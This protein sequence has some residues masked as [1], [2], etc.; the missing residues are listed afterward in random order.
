MNAFAINVFQNIYNGE[1]KCS[2]FK[3]RVNMESSCYVA[4]C[5]K[6]NRSIIAN[7]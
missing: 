7:I 5:G 3:R 1:F 4:I 2:A 6:M